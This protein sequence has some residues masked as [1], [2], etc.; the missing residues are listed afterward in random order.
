VKGIT[1]AQLIDRH[2]PGEVIENSDPVHLASLITV[3]RK[4]LTRTAS[5]RPVLAY[6]SGKSTQ[7]D[8]ECMHFRFVLTTSGPNDNDQFFVEDE[9]ARPEIYQTPIGEP[10]NQ[11][12]EQTF[13]AIVGEIYDAEFVEGTYERPSAI[14]CKGVVFT[15]FY[16]QVARKVRAGA[17]RWA[18]VSMEAMPRPLER[19]GKYLVIHNPNFTGVGIVRM[20]AN[21]YSKIVEVDGGSPDNP[22]E[23][24]ENQTAS[25]LVAGLDRTLGWK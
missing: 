9:L 10:V 25:L 2:G 15:D 22:I 4:H 24:Y 1:Y 17:G 18:A 5:F 23:R 8:G 16:P 11:D 21:P 20:P 13:S 6:S 14:I 12:H 19:V 3:P 7:Y